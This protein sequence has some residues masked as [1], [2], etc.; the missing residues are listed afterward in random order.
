MCRLRGSFWERA[1]EHTA[2]FAGVAVAA[3]VRH[4]GSKAEM[5]A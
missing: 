5:A 1:V 4:L 2:S 3:T